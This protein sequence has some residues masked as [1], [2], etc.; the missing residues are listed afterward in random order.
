MRNKGICGA[1]CAALL[2]GLLSG[3]TLADPEDGTAEDRLVG[4]YVTTEYLDLFDIE[5]YLNDNLGSGFSGGEITGDTAAYQGRMYAEV[6]GPDG[7]GRR[8]YTFPV[9]GVSCFSITDP[10]TGAGHTVT[11]P[12]LEGTHY[13]VTDEGE[14][15]EATIRLDAR[16]GNAAF[17]NPV[18]QTAD[19]QV[20]LTAGTGVSVSDETSANALPRGSFS[21]GMSVTTKTTGSDGETVTE[22]FSIDLTV[23]FWTAP[24]KIAVTQMSEDGAVL[25]RAEFAGDSPPV[26]LARAQ[27]AAYFIVEEFRAGQETVRTLEEGDAEY[28]WFT[29]AGEG[30][31]CTSHSVELT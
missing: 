7:H 9:D 15:L 6:S 2:L 25:H 24:D 11:S 4:L 16:K 30:A 22:T 31:F 21:H 23:E 18:Y 12:G 8:D 28:L 1:L 5:G 3:C 27:G 14:S 29:T 13:G 19:G 17:F 26:T 20:Y 10:E